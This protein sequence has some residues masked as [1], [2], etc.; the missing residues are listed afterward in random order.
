MPSNVAVRSDAC[1]NPSKVLLRESTARARY[2]TTGLYVINLHAFL[3]FGRK[4]E[5]SFRFYTFRFGKGANK[6]LTVTRWTVRMT[7]M[8]PTLRTVMPSGT[9]RF[10][11]FSLPGYERTRRRTSPIGSGTAAAQ[12]LSRVR[13]KTSA[14]AWWLPTSA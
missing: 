11:T 14:A 1:F 10:S 2:K 9:M 6:S 7:S 4:A 8:L 12:W 3:A 5:L 13:M